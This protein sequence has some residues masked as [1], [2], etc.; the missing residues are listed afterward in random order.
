MPDTFTPGTVPN[1]NPGHV[2]DSDYW[3]WFCLPTIL[4]R[5]REIKNY[6]VK[7]VGKLTSQYQHYSKHYAH[8]IWKGHAK[9]R[10]V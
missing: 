1:F 8:M 9:Y 10:Q 7:M 6:I 5:T 4:I 3:L 2:H